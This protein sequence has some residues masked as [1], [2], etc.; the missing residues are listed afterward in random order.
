MSLLL[1]LAG[2]GTTTFTY[3]GT[4]G[5][6]FA[7]TSAVAKSKSPVASGGVL[8]AG[9]SAVSR[10]RTF[11]VSGGMS[12][13]GA[14]ASSRSI[15]YTAT[16]GVL[17][18]GTS[19]ITV[20]HVP[21][22]SGGKVFGGAAAT[23]FVPAGGLVYTYSP[24]GGATFIGNA[25]TSF[26]AAPVVG[27]GGGWITW[28][29]D[30]AF[31]RRVKKVEQT[32]QPDPKQFE[33]TP[34]GG[35]RFG[36]SAKVS[37][38]RAYVGNVKPRKGRA[39]SSVSFTRVYRTASAPLEMSGRAKC[40]LVSVPRIVAPKKIDHAEIAQVTARRRREESELAAIFSMIE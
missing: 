13:A 18:A 1:Q 5:F 33:F 15:T 11:I 31:D 3:A 8:F 32:K 36:G 23:S 30:R 27:S 40:R 9:T 26:V 6:V 16:G 19:A 20:T 39:A 34:S 37:R 2:G 12:F 28:T 35:C 4:G 17:F 38:T 22:A 29:I 7:G 25:S 24:S 10:T 14:G 21:P